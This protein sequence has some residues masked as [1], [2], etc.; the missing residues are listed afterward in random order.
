[1]HLSFD[2]LRHDTPTAED[3]ATLAAIQSVWDRVKAIRA[4]SDTLEAN[5]PAINQLAA[6]AWP[7]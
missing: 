1:M 2:L 3:T 6:Q 7:E 4:Y 5:P